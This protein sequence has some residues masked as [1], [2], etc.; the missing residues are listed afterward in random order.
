[1][2]GGPGETANTLKQG[3]ENVALLENCLV[4]AFSGIRIFPR[5][6][7]YKRALSEGIIHQDDPLLRPIFYFSPYLDKDQMN[8]T[9]ENAFRNQRQRV[10]PPSSG[11]A[12]LKALCNFGFE[13]F[14]WHK[15]LTLDKKQLRK[16]MRK[17]HH[18]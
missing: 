18:L 5:T 11:Q 7:L 2:F 16:R 4:L 6:S 10:F 17:G 15:L 14:Q 12:M 13:G 1:M 9:I 8:I 3:L